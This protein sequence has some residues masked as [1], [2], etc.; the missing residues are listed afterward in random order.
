MIN[1]FK[2]AISTIKS[3]NK[4]LRKI[5]KYN[6]FVKKKAIKY[7][8]AGACIFFV[9]FS[10]LFLSNTIY[11]FIFIDIIG[12]SMILL[13]L[14]TFTVSCFNSNF[15]SNSFTL[16]MHEEAD[17]FT[18]NSIFLGKDNYKKLIRKNKLTKEEE[19][20]SSIHGENKYKEINYLKYK[21]KSMTI[22]ECLKDKE[23][24]V[25]FILSMKNYDEQQE[26]QKI[27]NN[28]INLKKELNMFKNENEE[29]T[30]T[31]NVKNNFIKQI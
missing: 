21:F 18:N 25:N 20:Y 9:G 11:S 17:L 26:F 5:K 13:S 22:D 2:L 16:L 7:I 19:F 1:K 27:L 23:T 3:Y 30:I 8:F 14:L 15:D 24:I 12:F 29:G 6:N 4:K 28:K 31:N 10:I